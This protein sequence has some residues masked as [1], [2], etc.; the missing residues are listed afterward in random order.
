MATVPATT[1][2]AQQLGDRLGTKDQTEAKRLLDL[3]SKM[4]ADTLAHAWRDVPVDVVNELVYR[5]GRALKDSA[6]TNSGGAGQVTVTDATTLRAPAD[7]LTS[8]Y[9]IIRRYVV[10]G[11]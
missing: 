3:A 7:P 1:V 9:P 4:V 10:M 6:K 2:T 11:L 8:S 5:V